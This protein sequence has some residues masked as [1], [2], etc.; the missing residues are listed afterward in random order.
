MKLLLNIVLLLI[1]GVLI[2]LIYR[3]IRE[4]IVFAEQ[5]ELRQGAVV[6]K[7]EDIRTAQELFKRITGNYAADFDT[8]KTVLRND[9]IAIYKIIGDV[10]ANDGVTEVETLYTSAKDSIR[11]MGISIDSLN[12][13]PYGSENA[14]FSI[15]ADTLNYQ[16]TLVNV[17]EVGIPKHEFM[18]PYADKKYMKY[19]EYYNPDD[20]LKF[21]DMNAPNTSGNWNN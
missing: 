19:N 6:D 12:F 17:V 5:Y 16:N 11:N 7:L 10:D 3:N 9:S 21:G 4:P 14:K 13:V 15:D 20:M 18:G 8:L 1:I 2:W